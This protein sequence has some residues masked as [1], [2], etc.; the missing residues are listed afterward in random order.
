MEDQTGHGERHARD[1]AKRYSQLAEDINSRAADFNT[2]VGTA[3][4]PQ[5]RQNLAERA[6]TAS[7]LGEAFAAWAKKCE[8]HRA[9][10]D[11]IRLA[12]S[13]DG[14]TLLPQDLDRDLQLFN[15]LNGTLDLRTVELRGHRREGAGGPSRQQDHI[16]P[17][18]RGWGRRLSG[19]GSG[20]LLGTTP[21]R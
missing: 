4:D 11:M 15:F 5:E 6:L 17:R 9:I 1:V 7:K 3:L 21:R 16:L 19:A 18:P 20:A 10:Q 14:I 8:S 2:R 12:P 13:E